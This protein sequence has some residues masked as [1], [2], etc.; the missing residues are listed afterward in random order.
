MGKNSPLFF[1]YKFASACYL[2]PM[3]TKRSFVTAGNAT[4]TVVSKA[5]GEHLTFKVKKGKDET[6]PHF[7]SVMTGSDN[8]KDFTFLGT[9]FNA[10]T[11]R[12]GRNSKITPEAKSA[13]AF[14]WLW[15]NLDSEKMEFLPASQCCRCGRKLTH[16]TSID[17]AIGPECRKH[18]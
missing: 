16:P 7:V 17:L 6:A 14:D 10:E 15:K 3:L 11:Y 18:C 4:F 1:I 9:I 5:S 8:E 12:H 13:K 2:L